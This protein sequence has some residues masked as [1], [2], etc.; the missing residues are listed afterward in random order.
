MKLITEQRL[1][2]LADELHG[3]AG[4][5]DDIRSRIWKS[6]DSSPPNRDLEIAAICCRSAANYM[7]GIRPPLTPK[8]KRMQTNEHYDDLVR[9]RKEG[10]L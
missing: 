7:C 4:R 10:D 1:R 6:Y 5:M 3:I 8:L 2:E 9:R